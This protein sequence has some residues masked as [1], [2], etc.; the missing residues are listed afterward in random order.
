LRL[1]DVVLEKVEADAPKDPPGAGDVQ[2]QGVI[3]GNIRFELLLPE[4]WNGRF[5]MGGGGGFVGSVQNAARDSVNRN[6]A[7]VRHRYRPRVAAGLPGPLG[8]GT[9]S[10]RS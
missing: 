5:V 2:V 3:G 7:T 4:R 1:P 6:Y 8:R 10:R 9:M